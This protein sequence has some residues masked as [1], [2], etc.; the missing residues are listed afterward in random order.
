MRVRSVPSDL[1]GIPALRFPEFRGGRNR[2]APIHDLHGKMVPFGHVAIKSPDWFSRYFGYAPIN[3][4]ERAYLGEHN[5]IGCREGT[6]EFVE[7][8][9]TRTCVL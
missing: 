1:G 9:G 2:V 7:R 3:Q 4:M 8:L 5:A 6:D